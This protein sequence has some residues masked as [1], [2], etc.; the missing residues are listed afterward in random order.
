MSE[1]ASCE[2]E[3]SEA[4]SVCGG[5]GIYDTGGTLPWGEP[6]MYPC[7]KCRDVK[8]PEFEFILSDD[9]DEGYL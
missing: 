7:A 8:I 3:N 6:I 4:C 9:D 2:L 1:S 5:S